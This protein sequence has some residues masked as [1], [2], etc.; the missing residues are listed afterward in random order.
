[1]H[2]DFLI[3][4]SLVYIPQYLAF[5]VKTERSAYH[6]VQC[7]PP[8]KVAFF[9]LRSF[10]VILAE[11]IQT[12]CNVSI[13]KSLQQRITHYC[14]NQGDHKTLYSQDKSMWKN[15]RTVFSLTHTNLT[16]DQSCH[17]TTIRYNTL[18]VHLNQK[19]LSFL[20]IPESP[21]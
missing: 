8:K 13:K 11:Q 16:K 15:F 5:Q 4:P 9:E 3:M 21:C 2:S 19:S 6:L 1:M 17:I 7:A 14:A 10:C 20:H 12:I 18:V